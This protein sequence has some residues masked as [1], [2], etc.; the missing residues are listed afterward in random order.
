MDARFPVILS[1]YCSYFDIP[2]FNLKLK[3]LFCKFYL[4]LIDLAD[5]YEKDLRLVWRDKCCFACCPKCL[6]LS[7]A[8][9][10]N[11][12]FVCSVTGTTLEFMQKKSLKEITIRCL[13]C[14]RK[15]SY[16]EKIQHSQQERFCLV[17]GHWR[18]W[19]RFCSKK[20]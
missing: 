16:T 2:F 11:H 8:Y 4:S 6:R 17:R 15:L 3:C 9:E 18:G 5:F 12:Y 19:C 20:E 1:D 14:L 10:Y 7:A 13:S